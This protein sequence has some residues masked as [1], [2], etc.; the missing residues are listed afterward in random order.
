[1]THEPSRRPP[2]AVRG[3]HD[4]AHV[5]VSHRD[6]PQTRERWPWAD[7]AA[8][9]HSPAGGA[10]PAGLTLLLRSAPG[11]T[12]VPESAEGYAAFVDTLRTRGLPE[13]PPE[14]LNALAERARETMVA[15]ALAALPDDVRAAMA[16]IVAGASPS[17]RV[18]LAVLSLA[19][20]DVETA[21]QLAEHARRDWRDVVV[22]A[23]EAGYRALPRG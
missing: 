16:A 9:C 20:A 12:W 6:G 14:R 23:D 15:Q 17:A 11:F 4:V 22:R 1:M 5:I 8:W 19:G 18:Q 7:V 13:L 21:R 2:V 10:L 3:D